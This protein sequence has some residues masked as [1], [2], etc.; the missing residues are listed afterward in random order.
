M[1]KMINEMVDL[2]NKMNKKVTDDWVSKNYDWNLALVMET[3][4][5]IDSFCWKWWKKGEPDINNF[6]VEMVD[7]W[8]FILSLGIQN[9]YN[10][11]KIVIDKANDILEF[12][13]LNYENEEFDFEIDETQTI[14]YLKNMIFN[15]M[16][17]HF[18]LGEFETIVYNFLNVW[19]RFLTLDVY[20]LY[21]FYM[22]KNQL[23]LFRQTHGYKTGEYIKNWNGSEDNVTAFRIAS[24]LHVTEHFMEDVEKELETYYTENVLNAE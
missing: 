8:H 19:Y 5:S 13:K 17:P 6:V 18:K 1:N 21:K 24:D 22:T 12:Q 4:E 15:A 20:D 11:N 7:M 9:E 2:Q 10:I 14:H 23:N 3:A 16:V